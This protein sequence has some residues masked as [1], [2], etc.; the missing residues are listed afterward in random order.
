MSELNKLIEQRRSVILNW[1]YQQTKGSVLYGP[2]K[3]MKISP[4]VCWGD[5]D[6]G[7]KLLGIYENELFDSIQEVIETNP[8]VVVNYGCAEGY[9]GVGLGMLL[10]QSKI[11]FVDIEDKAIQVSRQNA[12]LNQI[13]NAEYYNKGDQQ[14]L[15][16]ILSSAKN[17]F[18]LMD[19][20][21][22]EDYLLDIEAVPSLKKTTILVEVHEFMSQGMTDRLIYKFNETHDLEGI[23]QG[24]KNYH[25]EP[26]T[27][28]GDL[29]KAIINNENRPSTMNWIYMRVKK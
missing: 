18:L 26:I 17:P 15:E 28:L 25:V 1:L 21:G 12:E 4:N 27:L 13:K 8:D 5:G 22:A 29:D 11:V 23:V 24:T 10:P 20:E 19:C 14:M 6:T 7:G 2:F 16:T 3:G 9:Y